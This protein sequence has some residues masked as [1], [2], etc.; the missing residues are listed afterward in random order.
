MSTTDTS[1]VVSDPDVVYKAERDAI[2]L[3]RRRC[4]E[5]TRNDPENK[6]KTQKPAD[7]DDYVGLALSGGGIRAA[8]LG[9]GVLQK[10][11]DSGLINSVDYLSTVSG[12]GYI[13]SHFSS[14]IV[15]NKVPPERA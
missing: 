3:R 12:G 2:R 4:W 1:E 5:S 14:A 9:L 10:F 13:G 11:C 15:A 7:E 8:S 6:W